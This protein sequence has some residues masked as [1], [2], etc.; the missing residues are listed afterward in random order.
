MGTLKVFKCSSSSSL[1]T[2]EHLQLTYFNGSGNTT[3][4]SIAGSQQSNQNHPYRRCEVDLTG[5]STTEPEY[6]WIIYQGG[7]DHRGDCALG[8]IH[9]TTLDTPDNVITTTSAPVALKVYSSDIKFHNLP[10]SDP[11]NPGQL[12]KDDDGTAHLSY[13]RVS[14]E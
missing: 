4:Y 1:V 7:G 14:A 13:I 6:I 5:L 9:F 2:A 12:W 3:A 8:H 10:T 11:I